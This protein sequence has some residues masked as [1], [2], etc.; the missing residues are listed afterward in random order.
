VLFLLKEQH[1]DGSWGPWWRKKDPYNAIHYTW[2]AAHAVHAST[3]QVD[4]PFARR[5]ARILERRKDL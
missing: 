4:T 5:I 1:R 3:Y 2:T